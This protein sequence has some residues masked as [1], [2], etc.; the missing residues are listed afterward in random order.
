MIYLLL[1]IIFLFII[2]YYYGYQGYLNYRD[3]SFKGVDTNCPQQHANKYYELVSKN[4]LINFFGKYSNEF[5]NIETDGR[6][7]DIN[8]ELASGSSDSIFQ[9][10][11]NSDIQKYVHNTNVMTNRNVCM[12][13]ACYN[14]QSCN[15]RS[16]FG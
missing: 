13:Y 3:T 6:I 5:S 9:K 10:K 8:N 4:K 7:D 1:F 12:D 15:Y 11:H 2:Q 16:C 14:K